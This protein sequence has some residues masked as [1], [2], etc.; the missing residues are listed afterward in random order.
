[1]NEYK[2]KLLDYINKNYNNVVKPAKGGEYIEIDFIPNSHDGLHDL[3]EIIESCDKNDIDVTMFIRSYSMN[4]G[5]GIRMG[6]YM[7]FMQKTTKEI[8][9]NLQ[10]MLR[11]EK[12][13]KLN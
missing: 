4:E 7:Y 2:L 1:M 6:R 13:Q 9:K 10:N 8:L 3:I 11:K 12:L 5:D